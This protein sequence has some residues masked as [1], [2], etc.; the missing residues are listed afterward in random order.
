MLI[1]SKLILKLK[2]EKSML[3]LTK[4]YEYGSVVRL[5]IQFRVVINY[6]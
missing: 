2:I 1:L 3:N 5:E 6:M 4:V